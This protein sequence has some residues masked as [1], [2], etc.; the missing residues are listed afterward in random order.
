MPCYDKCEQ[1]ILLLQY[2]S[3]IY[4]DVHVLVLYVSDVTS[5]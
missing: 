1:I 3:E 5:K 2:I 4:N